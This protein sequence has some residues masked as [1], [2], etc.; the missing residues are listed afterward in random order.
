MIAL[1]DRL[2]AYAA[3]EAENEDPEETKR[4][5]EA[6]ARRLAEKVKARRQQIGTVNGSDVNESTTTLTGSSEWG[7][8]QT[9]TVAETASVVT[10]ETTVNGTTEEAPAEKADKGKER[11]G[12][13]V[14]KFRG[15]PENVKLFEVF[16][17]QVV[18]L[19]KV[20]SKAFVR[21]TC[22]YI[23]IGSPRSVNSGH[24]SIASFTHQFVSKLLP[25]PSGICRSS[26]WLCT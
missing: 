26:S 25:R 8:A 4:Q 14:R 5:E 23:P 15:I 7:S 18:E 22:P 20:R 19:I 21:Y 12:S 6:A 10:E 24:H 13:P 16:W 9:P 1:I 17:Q 3:R 2:A 11:E